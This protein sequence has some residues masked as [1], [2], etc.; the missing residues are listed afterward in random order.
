MVFLSTH[1]SAQE[2]PLL[3]RQLPKSSHVRHAHPP[4]TLKKT[5]LPRFLPFPAFS[6]MISKNQVQHIAKLAR[7]ELSGQELAKMQKELAAILDY[8]ELLKELDISGVEPTSHSIPVENIMREDKVKEED[9]DTVTKMLGQ[10]PDRQGDY[11][12]VKGIL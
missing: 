11:V 2:N 8:I 10:A 1:V 6:N 5:I 9:R 3:K 12:K 7:L 4:S